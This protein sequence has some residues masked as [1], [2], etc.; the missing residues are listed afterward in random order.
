MARVPDDVFFESAVE[1]HA[2]LVKKEFSA[3][4]LARDVC[5]RLE[6]QGPRYNALALM[7][8]DVAM[9]R[10]RDIDRE[11]GRDRIRGPLQGIPFAVKD[12]LSY[13]DHPTTWGAQPFA[14]Q[15]FK[16]TATVIQKLSGAGAG[17]CGKLA[18]IELAGGGSY[19]YA[20]AS[21]TGPCLNPWNRAR[22]AGGSSSGSA[23][24]VA[25]GL[26]PFSLGSETSGSIVAPAAFCGV[27]A[28]RPTYGLVSR[29]GAMAL[30]WTLDKIG[31]FA[32]TAED[33]GHIL[34][35]IAG[36][37]LKDP[38]SARKGFR[39]APQYTRPVTQLKAGFAESDFED[40][41]GP[42]IRPA[43][44]DALEVLRDMGVQLAAAE[45]PDLPYGAATS[46]ITSAE[47]STAFRQFIEAGGVDQLAD[48]RQ[49]AGLKAG[50]E[51]PAWQYLEA[52]RVRRQAQHEFSQIFRD[53]DLLVT[54]ARMSVA[55]PVAEALDRPSAHKPTGNA[56]GLRAIIP[57]G[58]L[59][60]LPA[61]VLPC[62]FADG[63][64][65]AIAITGRPFSENTLL[66]VGVEFQRRTD[67]HRHRPAPTVAV[68]S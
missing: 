12:L 47:G 57:A 11:I 1:I 52:M 32:R 53:V 61:L 25:A 58:N 13:A 39:Y 63:L 45:L 16:H 19:R 31:P 41:A 15:V 18:M 6:R 62:G 50:L 48:Q 7:L 23:A 49:I 67:W 44:R 2:R 38:G 35:A 54:P 68:P 55:P 4:D 51:I 20:A 42:E 46:T 40:A 36:A 24:V 33:C 28:L 43:L 14:G 9:R 27:T 64:P 30:S 29:A 5:D 3:R 22:W 10:A 59:A 56:R 17:L 60:G 37:D 65:V 26:V 66:A 34:A 21:S 8:R